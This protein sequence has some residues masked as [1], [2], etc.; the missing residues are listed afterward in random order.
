MRWMT[1]SLENGDVIDVK[2]PAETSLSAR[3]WQN[4]AVLIYQTHNIFILSEFVIFPNAKLK[5]TPPVSII[6]VLDVLLC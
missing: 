1:G 2:Y 5:I 6:L 4:A 3:L